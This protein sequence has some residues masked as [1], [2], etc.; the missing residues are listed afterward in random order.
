MSSNQAFSDLLK[1]METY[2]TVSSVFEDFLESFINISSGIRSEASTSQRHLREFLREECDRDRGFPLALSVN[3]IDFIGGSFARHTKIW[4][5]DDIDLYIPLEG[6][7][8]SYYEGG[9]VTLNTVVSD[10]N[11]IGNC[12][13][14]SRWM[15]GDYISSAKLVGGF[16]NALER[17]YPDS[18]IDADGEAVS[19]QFTI[20]ACDASDGLHFDVVPC[21]SLVPHDGSQRFYL[22]PDGRNGWKRTN[23]RQDTAICDDL[24][25]FHNGL[26]RKVVKL[27]KYWNEYM[28]GGRFQSYYV[29]LALMKEFFRLQSQHQPIASVSVGL[30][31]AFAAL[32]DTVQTG[33][34]TSLIQGGPPIEAPVL[35]ARANYDMAKTAA[36][37]SRAVSLQAQ[38]KTELALSAWRGIFGANLPG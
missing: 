33:D 11:R 32:R 20:G 16:V 27:T 15:L 38:W 36:E 34:Q 29:E 5:L 30:S 4:P 7:G 14:T 21:F 3:D 12:L 22:I 35:D 31:R 26:F 23:P 9:V 1:V 2:R 19:V 25:K 6:T 13:L 28:F 18:T 24:Q 10:G 37:A 17:H 8:L